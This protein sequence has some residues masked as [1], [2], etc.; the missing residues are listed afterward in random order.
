MPNNIERYA[1]NKN[2][3]GYTD[4]T[5]MEGIKR[6][7]KN[8]TS[9][10]RVTE[11]EEQKALI[12]WAKFQEK[13]Y[14]ELKLLYHCP[15]GGTRNKLEAANLK[16]QGVKAGVPD[17]FLPVPRNNKHGL[18]LEMKVGRNKCTDNQKKWI[19]ALMEQNYEVKVCY[20]CEEAINVIKRYLGI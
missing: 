1:L 7:D 2:G 3:E 12:Q 14:P 15:N 11:A 19:R 9:K 4:N 20:S 17:L 8:K 5:A 18:F 6:A 13:K 10:Q 16:R